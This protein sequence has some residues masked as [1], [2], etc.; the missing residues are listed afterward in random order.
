MLSAPLTATQVIDLAALTILAKQDGGNH[1]LALSGELDIA[2]ADALDAELERV[3]ATVSLQEILID[4]RGL[5]FIDSTGLRLLIA[6]GRRAETAAYRLRIVRPSAP[7]FRV[8]EI[9]GV[10]ALLPFAQAPTEADA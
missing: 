4:L 7:V 6:A 5:R 9:A 3:E 2:G 1:V 10:D 8:F